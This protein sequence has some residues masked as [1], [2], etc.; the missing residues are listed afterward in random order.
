M[1]EIRKATI[2]DLKFVVELFDK[3]RVF[4]EKES[5][6]QK[7]EKFIS[8]RFRLDD[9]KI[10]IV[11]IEGKKISW[12]CTIISDFLINKNATTLAFERFVC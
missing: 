10:F 6:I 4:Y 3:Y 9:S 11:E 7:A 12:I 2:K 1:I 5:D 8:E